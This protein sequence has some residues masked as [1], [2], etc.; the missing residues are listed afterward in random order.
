[1]SMN[2]MVF[3]GGFV[4]TVALL[5]PAIAGQEPERLPEPEPFHFDLSLTN[6]IPEFDFRFPATNDIPGLKDFPGISPFRSLSNKYEL[7]KR[8]ELF[9]RARKRGV[10]AQVRPGVYKTEPYSM[11][12]RVPGPHPDDKMIVGGPELKMRQ[13]QPGLR[14]IPRN[15]SATNETDHASE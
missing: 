10:G 9:E 5:Y 8:N 13:M 2:A 1:M 11:I 15:G 14:F 3:G 12:V 6:T 7:N 4:L